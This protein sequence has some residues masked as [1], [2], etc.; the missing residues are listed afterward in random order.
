[1]GKY[2]IG[3][4]AQ[5]GEDL[6]IKEI[7]SYFESRIVHNGGFYVDIGALH[8]ER[9]SNT[10][11]FY[12]RSW[13]GINVDATPNSMILFNEIRPKDINL[14][15]AV[16][17]KEEDLTYYLF[18]EP[19]LNS[20]DKELCLRRDKD[21]ND[22]NIIETKKIKTVT[23]KYILDKYLPQNQEIDFLTIDVEGL[24]FEVLSSNDW[25]KY[26]PKV[27]LVEILSMDF[28]AM[29]NNKVYKYMIEKNYTYCSKTVRTHFFVRNDIYKKRIQI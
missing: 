14:E 2:E 13:R 28:S 10:Y 8:P 24:D 18:D 17:N 16:S 25:N 20:F 21:P 12:K 26:R 7:F 27:V 4:F 15:Y 9:F 23:L 19:A 6:V 29:L 3:A 1:M 5:E 11:L 22:G